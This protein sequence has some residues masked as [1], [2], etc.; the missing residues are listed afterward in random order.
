ME[1]GLPAL[2]AIVIGGPPVF[3]VWIIYKK[4]RSRHA[5]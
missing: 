3:V 1:I 5:D 4:W 2:L